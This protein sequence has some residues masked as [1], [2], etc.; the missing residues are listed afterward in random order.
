MDDQFWGLGVIWISG[1]FKDE[2]EGKLVV[3]GLQREIAGLGGAGRGGG[4][5]GKLEKGGGA[6]LKCYFIKI[7]TAVY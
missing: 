2:K 5:E 6:N 3:T 4:R 7:V 1:M